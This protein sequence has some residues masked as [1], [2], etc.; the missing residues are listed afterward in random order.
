MNSGT[1]GIGPF[2]KKDT[3]HMSTTAIM[4]G[5]NINIMILKYVNE[6]VILC[7]CDRTIRT[8]K[9]LEIGLSVICLRIP[10]SG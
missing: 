1:Q 6:T 5:S 9:E 2:R 4:H 7:I 8:I 3:K 10:P